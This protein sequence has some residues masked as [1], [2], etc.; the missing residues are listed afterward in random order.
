MGDREIWH[1]GTGH[2]N[3]YTGYSCV[4]TTQ[5]SGTDFPFI[6]LGHRE[7]LTACCTQFILLRIIP[8]NKVT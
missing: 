1:R 2:G 7:N 8:R 6:N 4:P 5:I 3:W